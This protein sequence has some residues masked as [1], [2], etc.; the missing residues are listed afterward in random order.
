MEILKEASEWENMQSDR[1]AQQLESLLRTLGNNVTLLFY[2]E[3]E[4]VSE[5]SVW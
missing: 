4:Y 2:Y 1:P 5:P 3:L